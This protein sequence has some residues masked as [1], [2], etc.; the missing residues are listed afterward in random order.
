MGGAQMALRFRGYLSRTYAGKMA[1]MVRLLGLSNG[2]AIHLRV[3]F[4]TL[5]HIITPLF[6]A[7][8]M[9]LVFWTSHAEMVLLLRLNAAVA[10]AGWIHDCHVAI[11]AGYRNVMMDACMSKYLSPYFSI[12]W[13]RS[14]ILPASLGGK[15]TG[16]TATGSISNNLHER[17]AS[18]RAPLAVRIR[19][20]LVDGGMWMH[21]LIITSLV[22]AALFRCYQIFSPAW[23]QQQHEGDNMK[24][25][26]TQAMWIELLQT[27]A[28]PSKPLFPTILAC[29][30][31][32]H[33]ALFPPDVADRNKLMG[34]PGKNGARYPRPE[35][36]KDRTIKGLRFEYAQLQNL[37][38]LYAAVLF[39]WS[40]RL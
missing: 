1:P 19:H 27:V 22:G 20:A 31:P 18:R 9:P 21:V 4:G 28:W 39:V 3:Q 34:K 24:P 6:M 26:I 40:W 30:T 5:S 17:S 7:S 2:V 12:A 35:T 25:V 32:L 11:L 8:A 15:V 23:R 36:R 16:F 14:F 37:I 13:F 29:L 33:Y 10:I 38:V